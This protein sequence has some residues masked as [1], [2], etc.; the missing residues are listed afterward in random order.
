MATLDARGAVRAMPDMDVELGDDGFNRSRNIFLVLGLDGFFDDR[1]A[2]R[3]TVCGE[4]GFQSAGDP[5]RRG[6][7]HRQM[8]P[9]AT[10]GL[11]C[12]FGRPFGK[13]RGL[14]LAA[15]LRFLQFLFQL[16]QARFEFRNACGLLGNQGLGFLE[17]LPEFV[18]GHGAFKI[19]AFRLAINPTF[20]RLTGV[21]PQAPMR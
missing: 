2:T 15:P 11:G 14:T 19:H 17:L 6:A 20:F 5:F 12:G 16:R 13:G 7:M 1:S 8:T 3:G 10:W 21:L 4:D 9:L 18:V